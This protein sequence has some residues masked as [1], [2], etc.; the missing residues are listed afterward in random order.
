MNPYEKALKE[1]QKE[2]EDMMQAAWDRGHHE[3]WTQLRKEKRIVDSILWGAENE[4]G[5][6]DAQ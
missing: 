2:Y 4:E 3:S 1:A 5:E 6:T